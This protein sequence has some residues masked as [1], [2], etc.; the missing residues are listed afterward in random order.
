MSRLTIPTRD[1][2]PAA[3]WPLL[4]AVKQVLQHRNHGFIAQPQKMLRLECEHAPAMP[5][6]LEAVVLGIEQR[7]Q[8]S[9]HGEVQQSLAD[10]LHLH[11]GIKL[12]QGSRRRCLQSAQRFR[13]TV[14][15]RRTELQ[16]I[17][18]AEILDPHG[19][20]GEL[21]VTVY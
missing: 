18:L 4:D 12:G 5:G 20:P 3:S 6:D 9:S 1:D 16:A 2:A 8:R 7:A 15:V 10:L 21:P 14:P 19:G 13:Y 11:L 17:Q